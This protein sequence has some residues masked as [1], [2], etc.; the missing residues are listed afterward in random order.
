MGD[1]ILWAVVL[2]IVSLVQQ[3]TGL[4][5]LKEKNGFCSPIKGVIHEDIMDREC[6]MAGHAASTS[7]KGKR[8]AG[9]P[10]IFSFVFSP[11]TQPMG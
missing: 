6:V 9:A 8:T 11:G 1:S 3:N 2:V 5:C 10:L 4:K 7:R